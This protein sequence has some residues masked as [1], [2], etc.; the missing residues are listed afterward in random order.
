[1]STLRL[2][3][4]LV[5]TGFLYAGTIAWLRERQWLRSVAWGALALGASL[6]AIALGAN[7]GFMPVADCKKVFDC[8]DGVHIATTAAARLLWLT[9]AHKLFGGVVQYSVGDV[10]I[11]AGFLL[12]LALPRWRK[13]G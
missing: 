1:M 11:C 8:P 2:T 7:K 5:L 9:D 6:N 4:H 10:L 13:G 3:A 12:V